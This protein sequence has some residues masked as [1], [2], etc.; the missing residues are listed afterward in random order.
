MKYTISVMSEML[1]V[2]NTTILE[3]KKKL[4]IVNK[5]SEEDYLKIKRFIEDVKESQG[6]TSLSAINFFLDNHKLEDYR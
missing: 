3:V 1:D 2:P 5:A 4:G 6:K